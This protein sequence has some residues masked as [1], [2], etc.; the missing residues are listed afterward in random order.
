[1][2]KVSILLIASLSLVTTSC[3]VSKKKF[4]DI[5]A[6]KVR[7]DGDLADKKVELEKANAS[8]DSLSTSVQKLVKDT[9]DLSE[10]LTATTARLGAWLSRARVRQCVTT[11]TRRTPGVSPS[12]CRRG[13]PA[14]AAC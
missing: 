5:L 11:T 9:L 14:T 2:K 1:M 13:S 7:T 4:E 6:Q 12:G 3:I 10:H 8:I